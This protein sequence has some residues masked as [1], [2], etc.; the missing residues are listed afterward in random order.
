M[1][2]FACLCNSFTQAFALS[3]D[4][5]CPI[6]WR[7]MDQDWISYCL[8]DIVDNN[9]TVGISVIHRSERFVT[10]LSGCVPYFKLYSGGVV[11]GDCLCEEGGADGGFSIVIKLILREYLA[12]VSSMNCRRNNI[13]K[14]R[15][16]DFD[17]SED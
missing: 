6:S 17:K 1:F 2:S 11:Q 7:R 14:M 16:T 10:F 4:D 3:N 15:G 5:Y 8:G 9:C 12:L 13:G